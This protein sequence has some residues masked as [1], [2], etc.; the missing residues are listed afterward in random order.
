VKSATTLNPLNGSR[1][2]AIFTDALILQR[3][4]LANRPTLGRRRRSKGLRLEEIQSRFL[5]QAVAR[6]ARSKER[7]IVTQNSALK[8]AVR[9]RMAE[10][11]EKYTEARRNVLAGSESRQPAIPISVA[12]DF[13]SESFTAVLGG[14]GMTNLA[15]V[16]PHLIDF[17]RKGHPVV[18]A[19]HEGKARA[20]TLGSPF[21]FLIAAGEIS[22][23]ELA[24]RYTSGSEKD[25]AYLRRLL[26]GFPISFVG[27]ALRTTTWESQLEANGSKHAVLYVPD[28]NV[29]LPISDW[30]QSEVRTELS[31]L[32][33]MPAQLA[34]LK[35]IGRRTRAAVI[36]GSVDRWE[37]VAE[38]V[39]AS[40]VVTD[41]LQTSGGGQQDVT[42]DF[43]SRWSEDAG[44]IR[45]ERA[46]VDVSFDRWRHVMAKETTA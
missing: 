34:G 18:I 7:N 5:F 39:D 19:A 10:R 21:D 40:I 6:G 24:V 15:L 2:R 30:P 43:H 37:M 29:D 46:S 4:L 3:I 25:G 28:L 22:P 16:M 41:H 11:G 8:K 27:S 38:I 1:P 13:P 23:E 44:P 14:G 9:A 20:W 32:D 31:S 26:E 17:A 12:M 33:L 35:S 45:Q 36:G 42:L